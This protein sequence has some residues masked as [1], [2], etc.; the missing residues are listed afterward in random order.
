MSSS[1]K[2]QQFVVTWVIDIEAST[3]KEA[4]Q[5]ALAIMQNKES[6]AVCFSVRVS[7]E[8]KSSS[9]FVDLLENN[10]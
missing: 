6:T 4:A 10:Q 1:E 5:Q 3:E 2:K 9:T 7:G 8:P